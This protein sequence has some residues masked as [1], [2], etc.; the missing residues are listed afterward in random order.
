[1]VKLNYTIRV[2]WSRIV[3]FG[4]F[5]D[6]SG[7]EKETINEKAIDHRNCFLH[8]YAAFFLFLGEDERWDKAVGAWLKQ[9]NEA[10]NSK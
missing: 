1:M 4:G 8:H 3:L 10:L 9:F 2:F 7:I 5:L 6:P